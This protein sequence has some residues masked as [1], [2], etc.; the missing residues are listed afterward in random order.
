MDFK[1]SVL[2]KIIV[3]LINMSVIL[4]LVFLNSY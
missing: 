3:V 1:K 2:N 4:Y